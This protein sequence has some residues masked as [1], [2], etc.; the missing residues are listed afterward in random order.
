M[1][2]ALHAVDYLAAPKKNP[3]RPVC[4]LFGD[5]AFLKRRVLVQ[6]RE[7]VLG[8]DGDLSYSALDG[9][10]ALLHDVLDELSVLAMFGRG[11]RL[12]VVEDADDFISRYRG[13]LE[14]YVARPKSTGVLVLVVKSWPA[15]TRLYKAVA[16]DGLPVDCNPPPPAQLS[17]W[18]GNWAGYTWTPRKTDTP[19][20]HS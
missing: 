17:R 19:L 1:A 5:E 18:L 12:V 13:E 3:A 20:L 6:L 14:D 10:K 8:E 16:A 11:R 7:E 4:V 9:A 15:N 2:K